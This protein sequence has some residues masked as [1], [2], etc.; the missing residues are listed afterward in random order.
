MSEGINTENSAFPWL[1]HGGI[2]EHQFVEAGLTKREYFAAKA[3]QAICVNA[4]QNGFHLFE[5][6]II[7]KESYKLADAMIEASMENSNGR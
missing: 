7:A 2:H 1:S 3:M 4:G 5:K 6:E